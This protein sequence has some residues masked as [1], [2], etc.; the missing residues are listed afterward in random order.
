VANPYVQLPKVLYTIGTL[1]ELAKNKLDPKRYR[2]CSEPRGQENRGCAAW[3]QCDR[4]YKGLSFEEG[5]GPRN[6]GVL[7]IADNGDSDQQIMSC[8]HYC[9]TMEGNR[10]SACIYEVIA[11]E[12]ETI[13][14][15]MVE[16]RIAGHTA[17]GP[18][19]VR[20]D[21]LVDQVAG[22]ML[23]KGAYPWDVI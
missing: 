3:D 8:E 2:S 22:F 5:G 21:V 12:G 15:K 23:E 14:S 7:K 4:P 19:R 17:K 1:D 9:L 16:E 13:T 20:E 6:C 10:S 18:I 11:E